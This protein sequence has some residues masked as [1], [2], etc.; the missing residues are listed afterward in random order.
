[1]TPPKKTLTLPL[2]R[3]CGTGIVILG[4]VDNCGRTGHGVDESQCRGFGL[5]WGPT[6]LTW[7]MWLMFSTRGTPGLAT[8]ARPVLSRLAAGARPV[9]S[10]GAAGAR[11]AGPV[12]AE[13]IADAAIAEAAESNKSGRRGKREKA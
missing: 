3:T 4:E 12:D 11:P 13:L 9:L 6:C 1:M 2:P 8:G 7:L 10:T 5:G